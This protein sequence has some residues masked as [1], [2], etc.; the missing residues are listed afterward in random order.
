[1][2]I[3]MR[4][5]TNAHWLRLFYFV[6]LSLALRTLYC[7]YKIIKRVLAPNIVV[8]TQFAHNLHTFDTLPPH[9]MGKMSGI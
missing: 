1:M 3:K 6:V 2:N 8:G 7:Q 4:A 5:L 9:Y